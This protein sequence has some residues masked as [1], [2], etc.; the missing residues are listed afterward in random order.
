MNYEFQK[1]LAKKKI[2]PFRAGKRLYLK[3]LKTAGE[4]FKS[5]QNSLAEGNFKW[6]T[7]QFYYAMFH[8]VRA[9]I[10]SKGYREK[11]HYALKVAFE[12]LFIDQGMI[13][14]ELL[15]SF[16]TAMGLRESADY[17]SNFSKEGAQEVFENAR[18]LIKRAENILKQ[19]SNE[20]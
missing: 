18:R 13:E 1:F 15:D 4:D 6:A 11:S 3:E 16:V 8:A 19:K 2:I 9:L 7:I 20:S 10:Y 14:R 17:K 5:A 12:A